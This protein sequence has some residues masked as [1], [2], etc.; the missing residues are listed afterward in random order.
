[1]QLREDLDP[2]KVRAAFLFGAVLLSLLVLDLRLVQLQ[3]FEGEHWR[4][5]ADDNRLR[6]IPVPSAR[7]RIYDRTGTV[8]ADNQPTWELLLFPDEARDLATTALFLARI[9]VTDYR[10]IVAL[11]GQ[12]Y[13]MAPRVVGVDLSWDQ[14]AALRA[15]QLDFPELAVVA[16]F[17]RSYPYGAA[18]AHVLG[19]LRVASQAMMDSNPD[20]PRGALVGASGLEAQLDD[21]LT[22]VA[23]ERW[24]VVSARGN[25]LGLLKEIPAGSGI[26]IG[27]TLD[28]GLQQAAVEALGDNEGAVVAL[29]PRT[30]A[31][32]AM[33]SAPSFDPNQFVGR[34]TAEQWQALTDDPLHPLQNRCLQGVYPPGSTIKPF[35]TLAGLG[36]GAIDPNWSVYC[37]GSVTLFG[38]PFR[39]WQRGGHGHVGVQRSLEVSCD[40]FYYLLG[41]RLGIDGIGSWLRRFGFADKSG[42]GIAN[43]AT[44]L[45]GSQ[46]WSERVRKTP[47]YAGDLVSVSIGQGPIL[48]TTLQ[49][50]R[51]FAALANGG[52]LVTPHLMGTAATPPVDLGLDRH[53]LALVREGLHMVT[54]GDQGTARSLKSLSIAGK[55]GTAQVIR[56][57]EGVAQSELDK[58][59][60]HHAWFVGWAPFEAPEIVVV[61]LV[62][63]GGGGGT[64]AAPAAR[65]VF[66]RAL[67]E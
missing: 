11:T 2:L 12:T 64:V 27:L 29:D 4:E 52:R 53:Q 67:A 15:H 55:T 17:R 20:L 23:G 32:R 3:L 1:M 8:L 19:H 61:V 43:E 66:E 60:R 49:L 56:L 57:Q 36:S 63:H 7:G 42:L 22:G 18:C 14:V 31:V 25:Q 9:G 24:V 45:I 28:I 10:S 47:W 46:E 37:K 54:S 62:E 39:C 38:H 6:R 30:G 26:D 5:L 34:M 33:Y 13:G 58:K 41:Q 59:F 21:R 51:G 35:Y 65:V 16:G 50:A 48:V 40:T 44:G